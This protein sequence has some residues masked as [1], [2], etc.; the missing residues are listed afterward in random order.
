MGC[1]SRRTPSGYPLSRCSR[2]AALI[3][4]CQPEPVA[5]KRS[6]MSGSSR[7]AISFLGDL[8]RPGRRAGRT[9]L[10]PIA[11]S[12]LSNHS[13]LSSG[14]SSYS[15]GWISWAS[16]LSKL[17][18]IARLFAVIGL[19]HRNDA[20]PVLCRRPTHDHHSPGEQAHCDVAL[21]R[22]VKPFVRK[23]E[24][25]TLKYH[26]GIREIDPPVPQCRMPLR[27]IEGDPHPI[28]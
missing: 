1:G 5:R 17:V 25:R 10:S 9:T 21:F 23:S 16:S 8:G 11:N 12:A 3:R 22:I 18:E 13:S 15:S 7:S 20:P 4:D 24:D 6:I 2:R 26:D 27:G 19:S 14:I 28:I